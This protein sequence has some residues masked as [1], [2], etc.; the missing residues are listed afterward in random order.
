MFCRGSFCDLQGG[1]GR[2]EASGLSSARMSVSGCRQIFERPGRGRITAI[3]RPPGIQQGHRAVTVSSFR[4]GSCQFI[5]VLLHPQ[6]AIPTNTGRTR[7]LAY[8]CEIRDITFEYLNSI[9]F[10]LPRLGSSA[11]IASPA[12]NFIFDYSVLQP[13][14]ACPSWSHRQG[15]MISVSNL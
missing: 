6:V 5:G 3:N 15:E 8:L 9:I 10:C 1:V 7:P 14:T 4:C 11:R 2:Q 13:Q 12:P